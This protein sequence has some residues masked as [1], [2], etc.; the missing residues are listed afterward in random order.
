MAAAP[1]FSAAV[2]L[3]NKA[4]EL[5]R[6]GHFARAAAKSAQALDAARAQ[7]CPDCLIVAHL[8]VDYAQ[9]AQDAL[10]NEAAVSDA[11]YRTRWAASLAQYLDASATLQRRKAAGTLLG[12][13]CTTT[14]L[15]WYQQHFEHLFGCE[16]E[17]RPRGDAL[18]LAPMFGYLTLMACAHQLVHAVIRSRLDRRLSMTAEQQHACWT[19]IA[20]AAECVAQPRACEGCAFSWEAQF[21]ESFRTVLHDPRAG[22]LPRDAVGTRLR[23]A[24]Q[25]VESSGLLQQRKICFMNSEN[26]NRWNVVD[27]NAAAAAADPGLR[28]CGLASCGARE[29]HPDHFKTCAAC[30]KVAYCSK[31]HQAEH[32]P[33][34]RAA[35]KAARKTKEAAADDAGAGPSGT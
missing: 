23:D 35:C 34:H 10:N 24:W 7:H 9:T 29:A 1:D 28:R 18:A 20:D 33:A 16:K 14:E 6:I 3:T 13:S 17:S 19:L 26:A 32:W 2:A 31:E 4:F 22:G 5:H 15:A 30:R 11:E 12:T 27:E 8:Q 25:R 21:V